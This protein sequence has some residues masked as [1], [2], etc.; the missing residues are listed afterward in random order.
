MAA[1]KRGMRPCKKAIEV[2]EMEWA[3]HQFL[4]NTHAQVSESCYQLICLLA[5][6]VM[7]EIELADLKSSNVKFDPDSRMVTITWQQSK[8]TL[9]DKVS[10]GHFNAF[11]KRGATSVALTQFWRCWSTMPF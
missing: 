7:A 1:A 9:K 11:A 6:W 4:Q 2:P 3:S 8:M 10:P 5:E